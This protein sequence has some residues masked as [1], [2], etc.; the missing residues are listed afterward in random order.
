MYS[1]IFISLV[2]SI[3]FSSIINAETTSSTTSSSSSST[4]TD[5]CSFSRTTFSYSTD[6][7]QLNTCTALDGD[8]TITNNELSIIDLSNI[9]TLS[10]KL[11]IINSHN[12]NSINLN[13]LAEIEDSLIVNN[14]TS[15]N[16]I[17]VPQ[18]SQVDDLQLI[19]L[20]SLSNLNLNTNN[21]VNNN[22]S[23]NNLSI[24]RLTLSDTSL[25]NLNNLNGITNIGY[26]NIN[27]NNEIELVELNNLR[28]VEDALVLSFNGD[29]TM[30]HLNS[31]NWC[32]NLTVQDVMH[33][34]ANNLTYVN[35]SLQLSYNT[36]ESLNLSSLISVGS[37][38]G[39]FS[40]DLLQ[41]LSL[42]SLTDINGDLNMFN[43]SE[44]VFMNSS[45]E[46]IENI[47]GAVS[48]SGA[49]AN[50]EMPNLD[51]IG[52]DFR[53]NSTSENFSCQE[54]DNWNSDGQIEGNNYECNHLNELNEVII[55]DDSDN[56]SD[57]DSGSNSN[58]NE[59]ENENSDRSSLGSRLMTP[60]FSLTLLIMIAF[61][62]LTN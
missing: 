58:S 50:L 60:D 39:I 21:I 40:N 38:L 32:S 37:S 19:S 5:S 33:F 45:F 43:N 10:G 28:T 48:I 56:N 12:V 62:L 35:G 24:N 61:T 16:L 59:N 31:L 47:R 22:V 25:T 26:L 14:L 54:F 1:Y 36:F 30:V 17:D 13:R 55:D 27:N 8:I 49:I 42:G 53:I 34:E 41:N 2:F 11:S 20:P 29:N 44:L 15:L 52:G 7:S 6:V 3:G 51:S 23:S 4:A 57:T 18:L 46:S 9:N